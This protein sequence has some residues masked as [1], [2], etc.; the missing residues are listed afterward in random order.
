[1]SRRLDDLRG[2][3]TR[4]VRR[5]C[6]RCRWGASLRIPATSTCRD[7]R[8]ARQQICRGSCPKRWCSSVSVVTGVFPVGSG[9][10]HQPRFGRTTDDRRHDEPAR[11]CGEEPGR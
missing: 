7:L 4:I 8:C 11:P 10:R 5:S 1:L 6:Y 3:E 9:C 2:H